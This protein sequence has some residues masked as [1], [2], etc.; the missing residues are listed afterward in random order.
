MRSVIA[1]T[2]PLPDQSFGT[3]KMPNRKTSSIPTVA[4]NFQVRFLFM[5]DRHP[6]RFEPRAT[7]LKQS[8]VRRDPR[9]KSI[10]LGLLEA[11]S[12]K[13]P[14]RFPFIRR[15][16]R[17]HRRPADFKFQIIWRNPQNQ[18]IIPEADDRP[19]QAAAGYNPV[20]IFQFAQHRLPFF[21]L[22]LL[23]HNQQ[24]VEN[25]KNKQQRRQTNKT[26]S[27]G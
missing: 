17:H 16:H 25:G 5:K 3:P 18:R 20:P 4:T 6:K 8:Q 1:A 19:P 13:Q 7:R 27:P 22:L 14:S 9:D 26:G 2:I 10:R 21:L 12:S 23:R 11:R 24:K 15:R